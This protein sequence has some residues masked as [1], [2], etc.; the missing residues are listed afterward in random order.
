[1]SLFHVGLKLYSFRN[2]RRLRLRNPENQIILSV[3][4]FRN[5]WNC[6]TLEIPCKPWVRQYLTARRKILQKKCN[7]Q[8]WDSD[9]ISEWILKSWE[10]EG[11]YI[12]VTPTGFKMLFL[13]NLAKKLWLSW[14]EGNYF[15]SWGSSSPAGWLSST[16]MGIWFRLQLAS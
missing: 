7:L 10:C 1:M 15:S 3:V 11:K 8:S 14:K 2:V 9:R 5:F 6:R 12:A 16:Q 13:K 4:S